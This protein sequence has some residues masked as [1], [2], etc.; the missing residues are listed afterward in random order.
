MKKEAVLLLLSIRK[1][2]LLSFSMEQPPLFPGKALLWTRR[3]PARQDLRF[4][5][6]ILPGKRA[7]LSAPRDPSQQALVS[8]KKRPG[9]L[10]NKRGSDGRSRRSRKKAREEDSTKRSKLLKTLGPSG[11][12]PITSG[13]LLVFPCLL[14]HHPL[15]HQHRPD[16]FTILFQSL[17]MKETT[18]SLLLLQTSLPHK[19]PKRSSPLHLLQ[20]VCFDL[21]ITTLLLLLLLHLPQDLHLRPL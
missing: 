14:L 17:L 1:A 9:S 7:F 13:R 19:I 12:D 16:I 8:R 2:F 18:I 3:S 4:P 11:D 20:I 10:R 15:H 21:V 5:S 6:L